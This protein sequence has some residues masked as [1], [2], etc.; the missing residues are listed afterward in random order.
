MSIAD[1][2]LKMKSLLDAGLITQAEFDA[3]KNQMLGAVTP[4]PAQSQSD[5]TTDDV[6]SAQ[7]TSDGSDDQQEEPASDSPEAMTKEAPSPVGQPAPPPPVGFTGRTA[8][9]TSGV[10][11]VGAEE[12]HD[13]E[14]TGTPDEELLELEAATAKLSTN[15]GDDPQH[16]GEFEERIPVDEQPDL[17]TKQVDVTQHVDAE[18]DIE[19]VEGEDSAE[20]SLTDSPDG[21][22]VQPDVDVESQS[23]LETVEKPAGDDHHA[24]L[25]A[26]IEDEPAELQQEIEGEAEPANESDLQ[27]PEPP[28]ETTPEDDDG[29]QGP[30]PAPPQPVARQSASEEVTTKDNAQTPSPQRERRKLLAALVAVLVIAVAFRGGVLLSQSGQETPATRSEQ[31]SASLPQPDETAAATQPEPTTAPTTSLA[32][33]AT[34]APTT[35]APPPATTA[36]DDAFAPSLPWIVRSASGSDQ[37]S[38]VVASSLVDNWDHGNCQSLTSDYTVRDPDGVV[39]VEWLMIYVEGQVPTGTPDADCASQTYELVDGTEQSGTWRVTYHVS[40]FIQCAKYEVAIKITDALGNT[41]VYTLGEMS[42]GGSNPPSTCPA[43]EQYETG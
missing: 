39:K 38:K 21:D 29:E 13:V 9:P 2:L 18:E 37:G 7:S 35:T 16:D 17:G 30:T 15:D 1:E 25:D 23:Q 27:P 4:Q 12:V 5:V 14:P 34:S 19:S 42:W 10:S 26:L 8:P 43:G 28:Q 6:T 40:P 36:P 31:A 32:P 33:T 41:T 3:Q 22:D 11:E 24:P 20:D